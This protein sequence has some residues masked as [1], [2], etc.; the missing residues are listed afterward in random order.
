MGGSK[1]FLAKLSQKR[2]VS[3]SI[4]GEGGNHK[5]RLYRVS[6]EIEIRKE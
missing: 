5:V 3:T 4:K 2:T 6:G 1:I